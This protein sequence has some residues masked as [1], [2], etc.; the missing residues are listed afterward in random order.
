M[1][2]PW[3]SRWDVFGH[4]GECVGNLFTNQRHRA[5]HACKTYLRQLNV[6]GRGRAGRP[7]LSSV[8]ESRFARVNAG[9]MA[10]IEHMRSTVAGVA[11]CVCKYPDLL[12]VV[13]I[14][15]LTVPGTDFGMRMRT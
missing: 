8:S 11:I 14:P 13:Y 5:T 2:F 10:R 3:R 9:R 4:A 12:S 1:G 15:V 7:Q 6:N